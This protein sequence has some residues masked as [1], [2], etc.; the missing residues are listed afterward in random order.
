MLVS[1]FLNVVF[2]PILYVVI[3]TMRE[4]PGREESRAAE[5][6]T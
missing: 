2:I 3:E 5:P 6:A 1:T 4:R